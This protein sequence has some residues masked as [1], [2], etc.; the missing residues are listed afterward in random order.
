MLS[1]LV[2][3]G[4]GIAAAL[5]NADLIDRGNRTLGGVRLGMGS[6]SRLTADDAAA[7]RRGVPFVFLDRPPEGDITRW[8]SN[9]PPIR[10]PCARRCG[11]S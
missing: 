7:L 11:P 3:G 10:T 5:W 4:A 9:S 2:E 1:I 6:S 8:T